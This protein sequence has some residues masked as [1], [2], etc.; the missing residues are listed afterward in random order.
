MTYEQLKYNLRQDR[1]RYGNMG[2]VSYWMKPI[3][4]MV[5]R[6]RWCQF[7]AGKKLLLPL[8]FGMKLLF[9]SSR[10]KC[11]CDISCVADIG[12]GLKIEHSWGI[13]I[14]SKCKI[15][16]NATL[17]SSCVLG[18]NPK[19]TPVI[20]DNVTIGTH[21]LVIGNV[22]VGDNSWIGAG[23]IVTHDVPA[24]GVVYGEAAVTRRIREESGN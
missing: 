15:G 6:M 1:A 13:V 7:L 11:G 3:P 19:G 2:T 20:G 21:A 12:A 17:L 4:T 18:A 5:R 14:N 9:Q 16:E 22:H 24:G 8:Y 23:A 10:R